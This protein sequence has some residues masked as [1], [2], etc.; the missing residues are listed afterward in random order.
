[1][2]LEIYQ[3]VVD[4]VGR[5]VVPHDI[6]QIVV[7]LMGRLVVLLIITIG[8]TLTFGWRSYCGPCATQTCNKRV[9]QMCDKRVTQNM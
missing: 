5:I 9:T 6:Y 2:D 1:M 7:E 4:L 3:I 8:F